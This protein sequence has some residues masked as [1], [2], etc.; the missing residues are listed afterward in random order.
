VKNLIKLYSRLKKLAKISKHCSECADDQIGCVSTFFCEESR[1]LNN[2]QSKKEIYV[3]KGLIIL[4]TFSLHMTFLCV[5][6]V[7]V[8]V[9][10]AV[11]VV[12][13]VPLVH[14]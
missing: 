3:D 9:A 8:V 10:A 13:H 14:V 2:A 1:N 4:V 12:S 7:V 6:V 5:V 11:V